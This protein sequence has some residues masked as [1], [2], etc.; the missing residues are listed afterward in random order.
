[1][2]NTTVSIDIQVQSKSLAELEK[3]LQDINEELKGVKIGSDAFKELSQEAQQVTKQL[4]YAQKAA[5]GFTDE[6][7]FQAAEGS[8]KILGG[9]LA[10]VVGTL[11]ALGIETEAFGEFERKA[12]SAI[13]VAVGFRDVAEGVRQLK[14][15]LDAATIAQLKQNAATLANPYV[16]VAA[17]L[18]GLTVGFARY[19]SYVGD[20]VVPTTE[21]LKNMFLSLGNA[22]RFARLQAES[23]TKAIAKTNADQDIAALEKKIRVMQALGKDTLDLE[24]E[25]T[26]KQLTLLQEGSEAYNEKS[27]ELDVLFAKQQKASDDKLLKEREE[28]RKKKLESILFSEDAQRFAEQMY[29]ELGEQDAREYARGVVKGF[30]K[31]KEEGGLNLSSI[32]YLDEDEITLDEELF[33]E[34]GVITNFRK[35]L[36]DAIDETIANKQTWDNF[37]NIANEAFD[38]ITNLSQQRY[39]RSLLN[40]E[41][42]RN[43]IVNNASLTEQARIEALNKIEQRERQLEIQRIKAERDQFTLQQTLLIAQEVMKTKFFVAEQIRIAKL[44]VAQGTATAKQLAIDA[45]AATGK[46]AMSIGAFV[47]ALGPFGIAAFALSIGGIIATIISARKKAKSQIAAL[48]SAPIGGDGG[49]GSTG[50]AVPS[51]AGSAIQDTQTRAPQML[52]STAM[53]RTYV[54]TGDITSGQEAEA[55]LNTKRTIS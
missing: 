8:I 2:A 19:V 7:K 20:D 31:I 11:G 10:G 27:I 18:A 38:N 53:T 28:N 36:Q 26:Q 54:L 3:E 51:T 41:R 50:P 47:A 49:V 13:A 24:I 45:A 25:K 37:I 17:A 1:M 9:S 48:S 6:K 46:A 44:S 55:K 5:E 39:D 33:G 12:A 52:S 16:A 35:K 30:D 40:L 23:Y 42:E 22:Q 4:Q 43:E 34:N 14:T 15:A 32:I 21:T 29:G